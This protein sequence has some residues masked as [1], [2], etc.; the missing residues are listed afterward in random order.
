MW[1]GAGTQYS[2]NSRIPRT[3]W[4]TMPLV[5]PHPVPLVPAGQEQGPSWRLLDGDREDW[6]D[7][8]LPPTSLVGKRVEVSRSRMGAQFL[9]KET[10]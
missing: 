2:N 5:F 7:R 10:R 9:R 6:S 3:P 8:Q 4:P 1:H